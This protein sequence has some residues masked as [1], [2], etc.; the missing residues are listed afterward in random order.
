MSYYLNHIVLDREVMNPLPFFFYEE[1]AYHL[2][3]RAPP[4]DHR[5]PHDPVAPIYSVKINTDMQSCHS[6]DL[7][8]LQ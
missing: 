7:S 6:E 5:Y 3:E 1:K 2:H 8:I 4:N